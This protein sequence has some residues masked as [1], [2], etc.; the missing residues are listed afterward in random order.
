MKRILYI[1]SLALILSLLLSPVSFAPTPVRA[2]PVWDNVGPAGFSAGQANNPSLAV[3]NGTPYVAY[4]DG[5]LGE[6]A[7]VM[8]FNGVSWEAVGAAGFSAGDAN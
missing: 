4:R 3:D 7:T 2:A 8:R 1:F 5:I 6:K